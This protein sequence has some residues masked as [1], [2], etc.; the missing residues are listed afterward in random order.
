LSALVA[1]G[2]WG[3]GSAFAQVQPDPL[4]SW[5]DRTK[6]AISDFVARVTTPGG[7]DF[8]PVD[9]R[10]ATFDNDGTL[11]SEQPIYFQVAFAIDQACSRSSRR[12]I[13]A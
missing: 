4:P 10:I 5:S 13:P 9:E 3:W 7:A 11:W 2:L 8:V 1:A 6:G 12:P